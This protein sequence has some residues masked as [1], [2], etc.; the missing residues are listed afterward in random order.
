MFLDKAVIVTKRLC[1]SLLLINP[2]L[3][4]FWLAGGVGRRMGQHVKLSG[5][6][7]E[8]YIEK[9]FSTGGHFPRPFGHRE[10]RLCFEGDVRERLSL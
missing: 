6:I 8:T 7:G 9:S 4:V 10:G 5:S 1:G 3:L 2:P